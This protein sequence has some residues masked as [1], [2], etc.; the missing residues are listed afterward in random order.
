MTITFR[1]DALITAAQSAIDAYD[2]DKATY[3]AE[4]DT[5]LAAHRYHWVAN[6]RGDVR[7]LRDALTK[8]LKSGGVIDLQGTRK[9]V[10][11]GSDLENLFYQPPTDYQIG[12]AVGRNPS[13]HGLRGYRG[14]IELLKAHTED[15][16][17]AS[18]LKVIGYSDLTA[19][20]TAAV[21]NGGEAK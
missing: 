10:N 20:F 4:V 8:A 12:N 18:Q 1:T 15:T 17:T 9:A 3:D 7:R 5:Y 14:L 2:A 6:N 11:G 19:L 21:R 16:I 13:E